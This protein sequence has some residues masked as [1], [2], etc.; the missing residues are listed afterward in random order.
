M[1]LW[2]NLALTFVAIVLAL[3]LAVPRLRRALISDALL[4][5]SAR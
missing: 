4:A 1:P 3:P 2:A 5:C